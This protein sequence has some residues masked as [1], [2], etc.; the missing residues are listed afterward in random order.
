MRD[1]GPLALAKCVLIVATVSATSV[2]PEYQ[3]TAIAIEAGILLAAGF[4]A[5]LMRIPCRQSREETLQ[6][7]IHRGLPSPNA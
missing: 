1:S 3:V 4:I 2:D 7:A 6:D 5:L